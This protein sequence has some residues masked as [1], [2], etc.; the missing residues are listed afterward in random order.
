MKNSK[1]ERNIETKDALVDNLKPIAM[2][3]MLCFH[4]TH[5]F[6]RAMPPPSHAGPSQQFLGPLGKEI[7]HRDRERDEGL[8]R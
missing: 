4:R 7:T 5:D 2:C 1:R 3:N 8:H 6:C